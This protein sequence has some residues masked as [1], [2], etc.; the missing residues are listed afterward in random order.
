MEFDFC[1]VEFCSTAKEQTGT[2]SENTVRLNLGILKNLLLEGDKC[3]D[4]E[5]DESRLA[6]SIRSNENSR[7]RELSFEW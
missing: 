6:A 4:D 2:N 5:R 3:I 7:K 1:V